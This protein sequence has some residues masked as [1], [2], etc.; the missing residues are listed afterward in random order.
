MK[1]KHTFF[2]NFFPSYLLIT[3]FALGIAIWFS[4]IQLKRLYY[5]KTATDLKARAIL[6]S[7]LTADDLQQDRQNR[8]HN[9]AISLG[10]ILVTRITIILPTGEVIGDTEE[11][12]AK[13]DNHKD[14]PEFHA[15][16]LNRTGMS[17]RY[18]ATLRK[19][20]MYLAQPVMENGNLVGAVRTAVPIDSLAIIL[21]SLYRKM[22][23]FG[24]IV[25]MVI[26][27]INF[28]HNRSL[29]K[30]VQTID[31]GIGEFATGNLKHRIYPVGP[32]SIRSLISSINQTAAQIDNHVRAISLQREELE[33]VFASM[34]EGVLVISKKEEI[35]RMNHA[36]GIQFQVEPN[37]V[38]GRFIQE[39]IRNNDL[40]RFIREILANRIVEKKEITIQN[41]EA[42]FFEAHGS[43]LENDIGEVAGV[44][45]VLN[46]ITHLKKLETIRQD[47]VANVSHE[48]KT[49]VTVI[50]GLIETL[51][52]GTLEKKEETHRF[53]QL[54]HKHANRLH[55][56][57]E[58]LLTLS[59]MEQHTENQP[60]VLEKGAI[61]TVLEEA[62]IICQGKAEAKKITLVTDCKQELTAQI[63]AL[64]LEEAVINLL[65]NAIK[66]SE[67][68]GTIHVVAKSEKDVVVIQVQDQG[69]G[70]PRQH[71]PRIF[72]RFYRVDKAR[73][74]DLGG[75]G[76]GLAIVKHIAQLH[77]G[78]VAVTSTV[79]EGSIFSIQLPVS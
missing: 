74:R 19:D 45:I 33:K 34:T 75:S 24:L 13:M 4:A 29:R 26:I 11:E 47:F 67:P 69:V 36:A 42:H 52:A 48:L 25:G 58:D 30:A 72:E 73:S 66:F 51:M 14:R 16:L 8:I 31:E 17:V 21:A 6:I 15:A 71:L 65:D 64:L 2:W 12:P 56:I 41:D 38:Q 55:A 76:L 18:S 39:I 20:M 70:I 63:N 46:D 62:V 68:G 23:L 50:K 35:L 57:I 59:R 43:I 28:F 32:R 61:Q 54:L 53:V 22:L 77:G 9:L 3:W 7:D 1:Q 78:S 60:L 37:Q 79:G 5:D 40:V 49:P 44:L 27:L 10:K